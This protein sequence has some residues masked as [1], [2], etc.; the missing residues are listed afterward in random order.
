MKESGNCSP[1]QELFLH[2]QAWVCETWGRGPQEIG[3]S[4]ISFF[5]RPSGS[6]GSS[7]LKQKSCSAEVNADP[8]RET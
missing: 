3:K 4:Y 6:K 8:A 7:V 5:P 2:W 1:W